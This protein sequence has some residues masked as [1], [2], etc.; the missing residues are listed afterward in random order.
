MGGPRGQTRFKG[1]RSA[2]RT[3]AATPDFLAAAIARPSSRC[4]S[5]TSM[6][7]TSEKDYKHES[8]LVVDL[9]EEV[10]EPKEEIEILEELIDLEEWAKADKKPTRARFRALSP[11]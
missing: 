5:I 4:L 7:A 8:E 2:A 11:Q 6:S 3:V 9:K 1:Q 10:A